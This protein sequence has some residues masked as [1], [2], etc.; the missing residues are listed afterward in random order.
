[1]GVTISTDH[2]CDNMILGNHRKIANKIATKISSLIKKGNMAKFYINGCNH[3]LTYINENSIGFG[4]GQLEIIFNI[5][6]TPE[7]IE[8][9]LIEYFD[10]GHDSTIGYGGCDSDR[11]IQK[12]LAEHKWD[13][14]SQFCK[15]T[16]TE[17]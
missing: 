8:R 4:S 14:K 6:D 15:K 7:E 10:Y 2:F 11:S 5:T 17:E 16:I 9:K 3:Y 1:M 13:S 12:E